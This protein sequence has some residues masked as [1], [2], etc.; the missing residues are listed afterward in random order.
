M[1]RNFFNTILAGMLFAALSTGAAV[2]AEE[3][4]DTAVTTEP[5]VT[6][7][8]ET[9]TAASGDESVPGEVSAAAASSDQF[10]AED[11][12]KFFGM[13]AESAETD[14][15]PDFYSDKYY[16]TDGNATL[17]KSNRIIYENE[18]M[19]F[20]A[21][22]TKD[23]HVFYVL[24][25]YSADKG[26]DNVYFLNKVDDYDLYALLYAGREDEEELNLTPE[27]AL[28]A[29]E[30]ANGRYEPEV[31]AVTEIP[32]DSGTVPD[33]PDEPQSNSGVSLQSII[34][35]ISAGALILLGGIIFVVFKLLK[36]PQKNSK[37]DDVDTGE[38]YNDDEEINE[39]EE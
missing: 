28:E 11:M 37:F 14:K 25:N 18:E 5:A 21:V 34:I 6:T 22:T 13:L 30:E 26:E 39:D 1:K 16:D 31:T 17:M 4:A 15:T 8:S 3:T 23:G 38:W 20:I 33:S 35:F 27:L 7:E 10:S 36:K 24:I 12:M 9:T 32:S 19:Q 2:S 29:A